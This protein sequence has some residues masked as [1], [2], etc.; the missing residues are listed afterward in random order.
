MATRHASF[1]T[2]FLVAFIGFIVG[3]IVGVALIR[4]LQSPVLTDIIR[5]YGWDSKIMYVYIFHQF[6]L[7]LFAIIGIF[8]AIYIY[9][10]I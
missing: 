2:Y 5:L 3:S 8:L 4:L 1:G 10:R 6:N 7:N 9:R